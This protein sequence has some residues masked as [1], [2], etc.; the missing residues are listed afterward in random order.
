MLQQRQKVPAKAP[1]TA[2][3]AVPRY[4]A[5]YSATGECQDEPA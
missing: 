2:Q 4:F 5:L 3:L 1:F